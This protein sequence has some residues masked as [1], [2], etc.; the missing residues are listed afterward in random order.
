MTVAEKNILVSAKT[1]E[2]AE[3]PD[4][5]ELVN[6][7]CFYDAPN[8]NGVELDYSEDSLDKANT[9]V[10]MPV[11]A[12]YSTDKNGKPTFKGHEVNKTKDGYEFG[13]KAI[14][15]HT[16]VEIKEDEVELIDGTK[17]K[18]PCLFATQ[19]I[20]TRFKN[21]TAAVK[22]LFSEDRLHNSWELKSSE[23]T[24]K[25]GIKHIT[26]YAFI[27]NCFLGLAEPAYG[28]SAKVISVAS[29]DVGEMLIAEALAM[30]IA[31]EPTSNIYHDGKEENEEMENFEIEIVEQSEVQEIESSETVNADEVD[32]S[33]I[34]IS[35]ENS[36]VDSAD[37]EVVEH[38]VSET[39]DVAENEGVAEENVD[40]ETSSLTEK[41]ICRLICIALEEYCKSNCEYAYLDLSMVF[42]ED[43]VVLAK[44][45]KFNSLQFVKFDY[46]IEANVAAL[47]NMEL[48]E[49]VISPLAINAE[50]EKKNNAILESE[51][52]IEQ[53]NSQ[54][55]ELNKA[56]EE[57]DLIKAE[58]EKE[59]H[60]AQVNELKQYAIDS[61]CFTN[62]ELSSAEIAE[63]IEALDK[64]WI[65]NE[66]ADRIVANRIKKSNDTTVSEEVAEKVKPISIVLSG[67]EATVT[68]EDVMKDFFGR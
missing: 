53:L 65:K 30:D 12:K 13:T 63:K 11:V 32:N 64:A 15:T 23:Y 38:E 17:K 24:F 41:D 48:I 22:R 3:H 21:A 44:H 52:M 33:E 6:R 28:K 9:L 46:R 58:Q 57:L 5:L 2:L 67:A 50:I 10:H 47:E 37:A 61:N 35:E 54:I 39:E 26:D 7:V 66:I 20:W 62:D 31:S 8:H 45:W 59:K 56:K 40:P 29:D 68:S 18:L 1:I 14:G 55:E 27:G 36:E 25:D 4:Y 60:I 34:D 42:P 51:K 16:S 49:L 43:H 19:R